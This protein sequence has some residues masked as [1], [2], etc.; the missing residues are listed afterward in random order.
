MR[1]AAP[2]N[3]LS[4]GVVVEVVSRH[5]ASLRL[6]LDARL[7]LCACVVAVSRGAFPA[8]TFASSVAV[9]IMGRAPN[10]M[11][12][13]MVRVGIVFMATGIHERK[14]IGQKKTVRSGGGRVALVPDTSCGART[15]RHLAPLRCGSILRQR[16]TCQ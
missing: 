8:R 5:Y 9:S 12:E 10:T 4:L 15:M 6:R 16:N 7:D 3:V 2:D 13:R 14:C 1:S 11:C